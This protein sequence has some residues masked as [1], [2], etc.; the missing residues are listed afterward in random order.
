M[1]RADPHDPSLRIV[2]LNS[3]PLWGGGEKWVV[4]MGRSLTE[5]GHHVRVAAREGSPLAE[6]AGRDGLP[7]WCADT[8]RRFWAPGT[9]GRF[10]RLLEDE[11]IEAVVANVGQDLRMAAGPCRWTGTRLLQRR[12]LHRPI[13]ATWW[14]RRIYRRLDGILVN[15]VAIRDRMLHECDLVDPSR[16]VVVPNGVTV[17]PPD[18]RV[19][20]EVRRELGID[21]D[22]P[23]AAVV[24]RLSEMKGHRTLFAAWR[25]V[26]GRLPEARLLVVG[27]GEL[28]RE[29]RKVVVRDGLSES[30]RFLGFRDDVPRLLEAI[31]VLAA[32]SER[33]EGTSHAVLEA[34]AQGVPAVVTDCGGLPE[35][36]Q[37]D[38]TGRIVPI[39]APDLLATAIADLLSDS[40]TRL[41][42]GAEARNWIEERHALPEITTRLEAALRQLIRL[43][44][45]ELGPARQTAAPASR[46]LEALQVRS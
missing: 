46:A 3:I 6:R 29:C 2:L 37:D 26:T 21:E 23:V 41:R 12:G 35:L 17:P 15:A 42:L 45:G 27:D 36:V 40:G 7:V 9:R 30:V 33:D 44:S 39:G 11:R 13:K 4:S 14:N 38:R 19:R 32:P 24:G 1:M 22:S 16:F 34:M 20:S 43:P 28:A 5:R 18:T 25:K 8:G 10:R 31:D